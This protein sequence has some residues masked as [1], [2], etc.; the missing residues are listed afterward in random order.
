V[1]AEQN[2]RIVQALGQIRDQLIAATHGETK[3]P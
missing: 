2:K 3:S 1:E